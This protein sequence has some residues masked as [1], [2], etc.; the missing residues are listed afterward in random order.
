M[1]MSFITSGVKMP[2]RPRIVRWDADVSSTR[3]EAALS[4]E[5]IAHLP[6]E[7]ELSLGRLEVV[8]VV[9][10]LAAHEL[11]ELGRCAQLVDAELP[12]DELG[13]GVGPLAGHAVDAE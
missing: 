1:W 7:H 8:V 5:P 12:L 11:L 13:V 3:A 9:E 4:S 10:H 2:E 6:L